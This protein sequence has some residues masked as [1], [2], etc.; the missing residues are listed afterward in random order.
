MIIRPL[1]S[2]ETE[3]VIPQ[4]YQNIISGWQSYDAQREG[5]KKICSRSRSQG[6]GCVYSVWKQVNENFAK[7]PQFTVL[8]LMKRQCHSSP[9]QV[10]YQRLGK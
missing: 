7:T 3:P 2:G 9:V 6:P 8:C 1:E 5:T 4:N 10:M